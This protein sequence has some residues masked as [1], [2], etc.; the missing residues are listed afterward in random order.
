LSTILSEIKS[1]F[2]LRESKRPIIIPILAALSVGIPGLIGYFSGD[3]ASGL[4]GSLGGLVILYFYPQ[5]PFIR[6]MSII[7]GCSFGMIFSFA[8]GLYLAAYPLLAAIG[9]GIFSMIIH[10]IQYQLIQS[11]PPGNFFFIMMLSTAVCKP[12]NLTTIPSS[13]GLMAMGCC[14]AF[15][16]ALIYSFIIYNAERDKELSDK[17][18]PVQHNYYAKKHQ[19]DTG[20]IGLVMMVSIL[21]ATSGWFQNAYWIPISTL[22]IIQGMSRR[23]VWQRMAQRILGT[24]VGTIICWGV[25]AIDKS[26]MYIILMVMLFQFVVEFIIVRNYFLA[27]LFITPLTIL[28]AE[29]SQGAVGSITSLFLLRIQ[30]IVIGSL[31]GAVGGY[32]MYHNRLTARMIKWFK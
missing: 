19:V 30:D 16:A 14:I 1:L 4:Q 6:R 17:P 5:F 13:I 2:Q 3:V 28:L 31:I 24:I 12:F 23:H 25:L 29:F 22:A 10:R 9:V 26:P 11:R 20:W 27:V 15:A 18:Q 8:L 32:F 21:V 7:M